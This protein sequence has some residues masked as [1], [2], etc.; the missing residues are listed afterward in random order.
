MVIDAG[1]GVCATGSFD[2][3]LSNRSKSWIVGNF[4]WLVI[5]SRILLRHFVNL[6]L[7][8]KL[9][10]NNVFIKYGKGVHEVH[11]NRVKLR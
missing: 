1:N 11:G 2:F 9:C 5:V 10:W 8:R 6:L 4:V 7:G 3:V